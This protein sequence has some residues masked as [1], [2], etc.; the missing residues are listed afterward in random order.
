MT[1]KIESARRETIDAYVHVNGGKSVVQ[2]PFDI[3]Q[4]TPKESTIPVILV[5]PGISGFNEDNIC[6]SGSQD[7]TIYTRPQGRPGV[8]FS[9]IYTACLLQKEDI[10]VAA[11][12]GE[13]QAEGLVTNIK[14]H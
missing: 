9:E 14:P 4:V 10:M 6:Y 8:D 13:I 3:L 11:L 1:G 7:F 5:F 12:K 2:V